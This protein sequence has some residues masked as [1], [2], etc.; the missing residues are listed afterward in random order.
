MNPNAIVA[1]GA[2]VAFAAPLSP[3]IYGKIKI[4]IAAGPA[5]FHLKPQN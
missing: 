4:D 1:G 2:A 3:F 5:L